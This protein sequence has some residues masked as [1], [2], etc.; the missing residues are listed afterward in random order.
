MKKVI[1]VVVLVLIIVIGLGVYNYIESPDKNVGGDDKVSV[2]DGSKTEFDSTKMKSSAMAS[3]EV[4]TEPRSNAGLDIKVRSGKAYLTTNVEDEMYKFHYPEVTE[5]I[6]DKELTGF[7]GSVKSVFYAYMGNG[8]MSAIILFLMTDGS[9]EYIDSSKMLK[10]GRYE[11]FGKIAEVSNIVG[12]VNLNATD[13]AENGELLGGYV[14]VAAIDADGYSFD[15][16]QS[17][18]IQENL[19]SSSL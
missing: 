2:S 18:T 7:S 13:V 15:L 5:S 4:D 1:V 17:Q 9:V 3:Y 12:F 14:T 10:G 11:S 8:D 19:L 16:S 6:T